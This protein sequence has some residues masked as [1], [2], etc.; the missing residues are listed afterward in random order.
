MQTYQLPRPS[1]NIRKIV[2]MGPKLLIPPLS[3]HSEKPAI[4][5]DPGM[6]DYYYLLWFQSKFI[7]NKIHSKKE[8]LNTK[9]KHNKSWAD[10]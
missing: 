3:E 10:K 4:P 2:K 5:T 8:E 7:K 1:Q 6:I 9:C